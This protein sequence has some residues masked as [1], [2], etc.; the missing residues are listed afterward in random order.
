MNNGPPLPRKRIIIVN[1]DKGCSLRL[2]DWLAAGG[3]EAVIVRNGGEALVLLKDMKPDLILLDLPV[4]HEM[5]AL[6]LIR[7]AD[8]QLPV[9]TMVEAADCDLA[10]RSVEQGA[11]AFLLKPFKLQRLLR[12]LHI[13]IGE[14]E[15]PVHG[16][17]REALYSENLRLEKVG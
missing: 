4:M 13:E 6:R 14:A 16:C 17:G 9:I 5:G 15:R 8:A 1:E 10:V 3:Y 7:A 12:L 11:S 2:A